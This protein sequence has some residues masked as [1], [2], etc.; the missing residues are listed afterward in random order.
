M[1]R[2]LLVALIVA[3]CSPAPPDGAG[4]GPLA[5]DDSQ[6]GGEALIHGTLR[7]DDECVLLEEQGIEVLLVWPADRTRWNEAAR[8][9]IVMNRDGV[10][11]TIG[12]GSRVVMGGGGSSVEEG[13][14]RSDRWIASVD[15]VARPS[16]ECLRDVRWFVAQVDIP[17]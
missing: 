16:G 1:I 13:G 6:E 9:I 11:N 15:W 4:W 8:T 17:Q 14:L 2:N 5:V 3:G 12:D 10:E 7:I